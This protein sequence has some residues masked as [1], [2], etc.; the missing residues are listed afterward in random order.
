MHLIGTPRGRFH[1][2]RAVTNRVSILVRLG[3]YEKRGN[4]AFAV[5]VIVNNNMKVRKGVVVKVTKDI[6]SS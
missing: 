6:L 1:P 3:L 4:S 2:R 5:T